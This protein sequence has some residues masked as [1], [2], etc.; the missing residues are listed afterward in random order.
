M[1][2]LIEYGDVEQILSVRLGFSFLI[3]DSLVAD[4][5]LESKEPRRNNAEIL[6]RDR[7]SRIFIVG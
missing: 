4:R 7:V 2:T 5:S 6:N 3:N 1:K